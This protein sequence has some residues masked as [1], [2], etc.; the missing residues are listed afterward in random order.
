MRMQIDLA[1]AR[2]LILGV[3]VHMDKP[4]KKTK[5]DHI[6]DGVSAALQTAPFTG[7]LAK[8]LEEYYPSQQKRLTKH[9]LAELTEHAKKIKE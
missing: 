7:G 3:G 6:I 4:L 8:Y 5:L 1:D 2:R 9:M